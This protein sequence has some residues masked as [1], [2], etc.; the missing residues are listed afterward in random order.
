MM[1]NNKNIFVWIWRKE[2]PNNKGSP[3]SH[4]L[5]F[6]I[7]ILLKRQKSSN[8][9]SFFNISPCPIIILAEGHSQSHKVCLFFRKDGCILII[10]LQGI[11]YIFLKKSSFSYIKRYLSRKPCIGIRCNLESRKISNLSVK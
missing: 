4:I 7:Y 1:Q 10:P 11:T 5:M 3:F 9:I 2:I 8:A 6:S